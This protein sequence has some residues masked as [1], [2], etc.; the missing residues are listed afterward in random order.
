M[1]Q[2]RSEVAGSVWKVNC[3][4]GDS[5]ADGDSIIVVEA[6]KM[7]IPIEAPQAVRVIAL[8]VDEGDAVAEGQV[9]A[10]VEAL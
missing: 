8:L 4:V 9:I 6:M 2:I 10:H 1:M 7:E 5:V 3:Q